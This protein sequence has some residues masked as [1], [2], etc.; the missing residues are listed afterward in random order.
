MPKK[1]RRAKIPTPAWEPPRGTIGRRLLGRGFQFYGALAVGALI[2]AGVGTFVF[3]LLYTFIAN[4]LE[5]RGRPGSSGS[6]R[7]NSG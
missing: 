5:D 2:V 3:A 1:R 6:I 7:A 4:E